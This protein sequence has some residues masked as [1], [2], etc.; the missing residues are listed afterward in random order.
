MRLWEVAESE[1][2]LLGIKYQVFLRCPSN[3]DRHKHLLFAMQK[4]E[5][6]RCYE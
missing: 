5:W 3:C 1:C 4:L 6:Q 2:N